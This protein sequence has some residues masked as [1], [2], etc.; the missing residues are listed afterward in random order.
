MEMRLYIT[1][2][3][4]WVCIAYEIVFEILY[5]VTSYGLITIH[6]C[7]IWTNYLIYLLHIELLLCFTYIFTWCLYLGSLQL[8][9]NL[10]QPAVESRD[11]SVRKYICIFIVCGEQGFHMYIYF[12]FTKIWAPR[13]CCGGEKGQVALMWCG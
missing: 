4:L 6:S 13:A 11:F 10:P 9:G 2:L 1:R 7:P 12:F 3:R 8:P 5:V